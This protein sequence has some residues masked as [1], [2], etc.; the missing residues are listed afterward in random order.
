[1]GAG[2]S[3]MIVFQS[4]SSLLH[5]PASFFRRGATLEHPESAGRYAVLV[6]AV[7]K[8]GHEVRAPEDF[9]LAPIADVHD[10]D[11]LDFLQYAWSRRGEVAG[12]G[13]ELIASHFARLAEHRR[14]EGLTGQLGWYTS[15][16]STAILE[17][18]WPAIYGA[19]QAAAA[20]ADEAIATGAAY[21]LSRPPGHHAH[22]ALAAGFCYLNNTAVAAQ[23]LVS[24]TGGKVAVLDIDAHHGNG[25]QAIFYDRDDVLTVS[26]HGDP[27]NF[28]PFFSGYADE[29]GAGKGA[30]F[31]LNIPLPHGAGDEAFLAAVDR[32]L[33]AIRGFG[34]DALVVAL[35]LD[36]AAEDPLGVMTV[37]TQGFARAA[38]KIAAFGG[39]TVLVQEGGYLCDALPRNLSTFLETFER[40]RK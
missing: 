11:Y 9:G 36:G 30:G 37:S 23:R 38:E 18:T 10:A 34:P 1:M 5:A 31:N 35:G 7:R 19:A 28:Y 13:D 26:L 2:E 25:T 39:P 8:A 22:G 29:I 33:E 21:A 32:G 27:T 6:E 24:K 4:P 16:T 3:S 15:D 20:A 12:A 40:A 17:E 14:P